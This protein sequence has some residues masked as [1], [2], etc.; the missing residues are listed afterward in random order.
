MRL[1]VKKVIEELA[2]K[3]YGLGA[4]R[5][6]CFSIDPPLELKCRENHKRIKAGEIVHADWID[7][8]GDLPGTVHIKEKGLRWR[9][10]R[11]DLVS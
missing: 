3:R 8:S 7:V 6:G 9:I 11:F 10:K 5:T 4:H 2:R 1:T